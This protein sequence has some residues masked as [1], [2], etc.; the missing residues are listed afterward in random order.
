MLATQQTSPANPMSYDEVAEKFR[1]CA[2]YVG[3]PKDKTDAVITF[4]K[5]LESAPDVGRLS[6]L[7]GS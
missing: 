3:W 4:V 1:G 7:L 5:T 6:A 2:E